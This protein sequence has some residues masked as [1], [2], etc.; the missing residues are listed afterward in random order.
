MTTASSIMRFAYHA[1]DKAD[2]SFAVELHD[3]THTALANWHDEYP[4]RYFYVMEWQNRLGETMKVQDVTSVRNGSMMP[5]RVYQRVL[6]KRVVD[7]I[8]TR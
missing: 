1:A 7:L 5:L 4:Y 6:Q 2:G 3:A 8:S